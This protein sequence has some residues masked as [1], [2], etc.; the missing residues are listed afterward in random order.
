M[1]D[2]V[3]SIETFFWEDGRSWQYV[4]QCV[5]RDSCLTFFLAVSE[6]AAEDFKESGRYLLLSENVIYGDAEYN[7]ESG[8]ARVTGETTLGTCKPELCNNAG[9]SSMSLEVEANHSGHYILEWNVHQK[10]RTDKK[11]TAK[12]YFGYNRSGYRHL[13]CIPSQCFA[14]DVHV[15]DQED[16]VKSLSLIHI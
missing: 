4:Q 14:L 3:A 2:R 12:G 8:G 6:A 16:A 15:E 13:G 7:F 5:K 9:A 11:G 1:E 10:G